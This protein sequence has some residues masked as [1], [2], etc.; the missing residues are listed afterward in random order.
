[1]TLRRY[2]QEA[3]GVARELLVHP[4]AV[5]TLSWLTRDRKLTNWDLGEPWWNP[6]AISYLAAH[7][8]RGDRVWEWGSGGSTVWLVEHGAKVTSI[9]EDVEWAAKVQER[10]PAADVRFVGGSEH[11]VLRSRQWE[12]SEKF[13]DD[14]VSAI[15]E[16]PDE[17]VA[18]VIVDGRCRLDCVRHAVPKVR[19][20][21]L[22]AL[23]DS[24]QPFLSFAPFIPELDGWQV[25][26][27]GGFKRRSLVFTETTFL[28]KTGA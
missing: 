27:K 12:V 24:E 11:G 13:F 15:D 14:C 9:E 8:K 28:H 25:V 2:V 10:C 23:D 3:A 4:D 21:G 18:V 17:S 20:G 26:K 1:M 22:I 19:E 6:L 5:A 16:E 7:L